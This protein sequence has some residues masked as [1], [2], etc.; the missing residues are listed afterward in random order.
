MEEPVI[1][2]SFK[3][4]KNNIIDLKKENF[5]IGKNYVKQE[6]KWPKRP[7]QSKISK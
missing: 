5:T 3:F 2:S 4:T 7:E 1:I 6:D